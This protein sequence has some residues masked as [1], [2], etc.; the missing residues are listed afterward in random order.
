MKGNYS[1][2]I[3]SLFFISSWACGTI[4]TPTENPEPAS[5]ASL[6]PL[7]PPLEKVEFP[8]QAKPYPSYWPE[9]L[10]F[11][12][13]FKP[14][15]FIQGTMPGGI[16]TN[17]SLKTRF[18][19]TIEN[20][21]DDLRAFLAQKNWQIVDETDLDTGGKVWIIQ[22]DTNSSGIV[23]IDTQAEEKVVIIATFYL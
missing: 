12:E 16:K 5:E 14:V 11:P 19:G 4:Q 15:E 21:A 1:W 17:L 10:H 13:A 7:P 9:E 23:V 20:A 3:L 22:K 6:E 18:G 2:L 8:E